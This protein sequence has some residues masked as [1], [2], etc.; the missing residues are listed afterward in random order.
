MS[1]ILPDRLALSTC[2]NSHRHTDGYEMILEIRELGFQRI[3]LSH[4]VPSYLVEGVLRALQEKIVSVDSVHNFCPLPAMVT[5]AAPNLF[6]PSSRRRLE[7]NSWVRY[8]LQTLAFAAQVSATHVVM[9]SGSLPP[10]KRHREEDLSVP[11]TLSSEEMEKACQRLRKRARK[12]IP[13]VRSLYQKLLPAARERNLI[14]GIENREAILELPLDN[15]FPA[16]L[17]DFDDLHLAYWHDTGHAEI[18]NRLS[19][20]DPAAHLESLSERLTGFH[21]HDV[22]EEGRDHQP[23]GSGTVD[24]RQ[25]KAFLRPE[26]LLVIELSPRLTRDEVAES[27]ARLIEFLS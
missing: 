18:K 22:S 8:S 11:G 17:A 16:F 2:W 7:R 4:G 14:L 10:R 24:F 26:H 6:Q 23:I 27:R 1:E 25:L 3:E 9:H 21:L 5:H 19:L 20:L 15:D 13:R 12:T